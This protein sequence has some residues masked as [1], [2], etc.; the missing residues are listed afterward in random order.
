[1]YPL[2]L[3][4]GVRLALCALVV[5]EVASSPTLAQ[6]TQV[7]AVPAVSIYQAW[8]NGDTITAGSDSTVF[9]SLD[10]GATWTATAKVASGVT[11]VRAVRVHKGRLYAGTLGQGVFVSSNMGGTWQSFNQGLVGGIN[12]FQLHHGPAAPWRQ[13]L[14][15]DRRLRALD[16]KPGERSRVVALRQRSR[17][18]SGRDA[19][20]PRRDQR[21][22][23]A[24]RSQGISW[25]PRSPA[26]RSAPAPNAR[27]PT[28]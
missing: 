28:S 4:R 20:R 3:H 9:V 18:C 27:R 19:C 8:T 16:S 14:R 5:L 15:R 23:P 6:W 26:G 17:A 7:N 25:A 2:P 10:A 22:R 1:M 13:P 11:M 21:N 12:N 24:G